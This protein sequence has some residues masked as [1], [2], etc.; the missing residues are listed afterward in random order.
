ML[1]RETF[2]IV[3][4][5][6]LYRFNH[7]GRIFNVN[8]ANQHVDKSP[9]RVFDIW[10]R[11]ITTRSQVTKQN[12]GGTC[13]CA[14]DQTPGQLEDVGERDTVLLGEGLELLHGR[15]W[16]GNFDNTELFSLFGDVAEKWK[17][18]RFC[19]EKVFLPVSE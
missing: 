17:V 5:D 11:H 10:D 2:Q 14:Q 13:K 12:V 7:R 9:D 15:P 18:A 19:P 3:V 8:A 16:D 6:L 4:L 1:M